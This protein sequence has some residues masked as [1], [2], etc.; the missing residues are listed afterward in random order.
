MGVPAHDSR[1]YDFAKKF[2]LK[3]IRVINNPEEPS[4]LPYLERGSSSTRMNLTA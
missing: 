3:I 4:A 1:D 2:N